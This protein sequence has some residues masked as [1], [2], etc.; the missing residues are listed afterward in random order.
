MSKSNFEKISH[1]RLLGIL[2]IIAYFLLMFGNGRLSL[3][4]PDEVFYILSAREMVEHDS[5]LTPMIFGQIQFEKPILSYA[6]FASVIKF[7]GEGPFVARFWPSLFGI[8]GIGVVYWISWMLFGRK[9]IAFLSGLILASSGIYMVLSRAVLT[10]MI[11]TTFVSAS[12]G[13]FYLAINDNRQH[14][15]GMIWGFF[16]CALAVL[17]KGILG[18][19][20]P[21]AT[22]MMY[23]A[24]TGQMKKVNW[25]IFGFGFVFFLILAAPWHFLMLKKY[26]AFFIQEYFENVHFRRLFQAEHPKMSTV[27]FYP[28][29]MIVGVLPWSFFWILTIQN[30]IRIIKERALQVDKVKFLLSWIVCVFVP[31][32]LAVSKLASY[33]FPLFP[34]LAI[35]LG[36]SI[37]LAMDEKMEKTPQRQ[38]MKLAAWLTFIFLAAGSIGIIIASFHFNY[39]ATDKASVL[40]VSWMLFF[41]ALAVI[42]FFYRKLY[43][44]M[45]VGVTAFVPIVLIGAILIMPQLESMTSCRN[46]CEVFK[47]MNKP[48]EIIFSSKIMARAVHFYTKNPV[49]VIDINGKGFWSKHPVPYFNLDQMIIDYMN[50]HG[51]LYAIIRDKTMEDF[52]RLSQTQPY[53]IKELYSGGGKKIILVVKRQQS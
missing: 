10:D 45:I 38:S 29:M 9:K 44:R 43:A 35:L 39:W 53:E 2:G 11:F 27:Y 23:L 8:L 22:I 15:R 20:F 21:L 5:W 47:K 24:W 28:L 16:F 14:S 41:S 36:F 17:T 4:H 49:A 19:V 46:I 34:A 7:F 25:K 33:V 26:G 13:F 40:A 3:T 31:V 50:A 51:Q 12:I 37:I 18:F 48:N 32:Q 1:K 6:L 52:D 30:I 42:L